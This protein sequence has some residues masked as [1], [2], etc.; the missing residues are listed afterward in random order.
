MIFIEKRKS[1]NLYILAIESHM[2][3][4]LWINICVNTEVN[5]LALCCKKLPYSSAVLVVWKRKCMWKKFLYLSKDT[6][7]LNNKWQWKWVF[8]CC[9]DDFQKK[10]C[11]WHFCLIC[12]I[13]E[14]EYHK[15]SH[16]YIFKVGGVWKILYCSGWHILL[17]I[18]KYV[19]LTIFRQSMKFVM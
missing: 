3:I 17:C 7:N 2:S 14:V 16:Y 5:F 4:R 1:S 15:S 12:V 10:L 8:S 11:V 6:K 9:D 13:V 18:F 19:M